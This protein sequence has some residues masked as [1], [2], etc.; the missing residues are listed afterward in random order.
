M[1]LEILVGTD[2]NFGLFLLYNPLTTV[3]FSH[4]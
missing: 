1:E 3:I 4:L 2:C